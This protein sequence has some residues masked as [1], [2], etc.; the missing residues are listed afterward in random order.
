MK[1]R[2]YY[3]IAAPNSTIVHRSDSH[4]EGAIMFCGRVTRMGWRYYVQKRTVPKGR[5][6]CVGCS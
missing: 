5:T 4:I 3:Y 2:R 6:M 1:V